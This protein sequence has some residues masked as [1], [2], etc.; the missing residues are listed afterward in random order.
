MTGS[1]VAVTDLLVLKSQCDFNMIAMIFILFLLSI[2]VYIIW[3]IIFYPFIV[4]LFQKRS[5]V[6]F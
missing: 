4:A 6:V 1:R 2:T 5:T 3:F